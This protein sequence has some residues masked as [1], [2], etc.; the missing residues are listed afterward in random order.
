MQNECVSSHRA[1]SSSKCASS[2]AILLRSLG[3]YAWYA[4]DDARTEGK[5]KGQRG[6]G[7][8]SS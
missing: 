2:L 1:S 3:L 4:K 7:I 5:E 6:G 8:W